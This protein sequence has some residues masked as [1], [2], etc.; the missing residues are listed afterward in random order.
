MFLGKMDTFGIFQWLLGLGTSHATQVTDKRNE[1]AK[2][3][4]EISAE[5]G[6]VSD[7]INLERR[8]LL[9]RCNM[10][11]P[12]DPSTEQAFIAALE[13][14]TTTN[15]QLRDL[16]ES[17]RQSPIKASTF[18]DWDTILR[19]YYEWRGTASR[20]VPWTEGVIAQLH[21]VLDSEERRR[22]TGDP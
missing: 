16:V 21:S 8:R 6:R 2:L 3:S 19:S 20:I 9:S 4:A 1:A 18:A 7:L 22:T 14:L 12:D 10:L 11:F 5:V 17:N 13:Q 15:N